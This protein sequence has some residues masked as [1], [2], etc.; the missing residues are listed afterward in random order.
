MTPDATPPF[1]QQWL[2]TLEAASLDQLVPDPATTAIF[3]ADMINGFL[4]FGVLS[5]ARVRNLAEPVTALFQAAWDHG[6]RNFV[7]CQ[8]THHPDTPEFAAYPPHCLDDSPESDTIPELASL[9]F[10]SAFTIVEKNSLS[11]AIATALDEWLTMNRQVT[12]AIVV[13]DCTDLCTYQLAMYLRMR[14]NALNIAGY[15]VV[16]PMDAVDTFDIPHTEAEWASNTH[17]AEFFHTVFLYHMAQNGI[18]VVT[19]IS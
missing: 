8:D 4:H 6:I 7:L 15:S 13:G 5:S 12:T 17:P 14:A 11:P 3:S 2:E 19:S 1:V 9:P 16:V 18:S 10:A